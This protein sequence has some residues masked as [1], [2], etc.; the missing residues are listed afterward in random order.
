MFDDFSSNKEM[1]DFSN[2][3]TKPKEYDNLNK[4]VIRKMKY[5]SAGVAIKEFLGLK[6]K[7]DSFLVEDNNE[8]RK[9]K[10]VNRNVVATIRPNEY[11]DVLL[12]NKC[13]RN[14]MNRIQSKHHRKGT[15]EM[16][17]VSLSCFENNRYGGLALNYYITNYKNTS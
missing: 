14:S 9:A 5:E 12:N 15:Y 17:K 2:C 7:I 10:G 1:F 11:K 16:N 6:T 3:S 4:L 13:I 8:Y